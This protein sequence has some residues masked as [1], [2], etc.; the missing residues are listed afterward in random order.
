MGMIAGG[1]AGLAATLTGH[2]LA[3]QVFKFDYSMTPLPTMIG[4]IAGTVFIS[5]IG[6]LASNKVLSQPPIDTFRQS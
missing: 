3:K 4:L 2:F 6:L 5:L 1:I